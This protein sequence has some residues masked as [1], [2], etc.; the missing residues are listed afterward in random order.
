MHLRLNILLL[1][2]EFSLLAL[3][4]TSQHCQLYQERGVQSHFNHSVPSPS[5][6]LIHGSPTRASS[7]HPNPSSTSFVYGTDKIRGV[8]LYVIPRLRVFLNAHD[9][10]LEVAGS[11]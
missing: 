2:L 1:V 10:L 9:L 11:C 5:P 4:A 3:L 6:S 7:A 8:N